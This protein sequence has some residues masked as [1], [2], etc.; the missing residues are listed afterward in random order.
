MSISEWFVH[1]RD[2]SVLIADVYAITL[3]SVA[4]V[5]IKMSNHVSYSPLPTNNLIKSSL[6]QTVSC[7]HGICNM[8][9]E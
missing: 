6:F 1:K 9:H 8:V 3:D 7:L 5:S 2:R 4:P